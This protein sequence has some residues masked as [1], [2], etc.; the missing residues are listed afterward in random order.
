MAERS[1]NYI[2]I[3]AMVIFTA[4]VSYWVRESPSQV[5]YQPDLAAI[6]RHLGRWEGKDLDLT[7]EVLDMLNADAVLSRAYTDNHY[8]TQVGL[9]IEYRKYGR[10]DFIHRPEECY[11]NAGW[12]I[13]ETGTSRHAVCAAGIFRLPRSLHRR[14]S[15]VVPPG[16]ILVYWYASWTRDRTQLF[17]ATVE[18]GPRPLSDTQIWLDI[19]PL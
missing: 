5:L 3:L 11:P 12:E 1:P 4:I 8:G 2:L 15:T 16:D 18:N 6:P 14:R 10:R 13:V 9:L 19:Y 17:E 7:K